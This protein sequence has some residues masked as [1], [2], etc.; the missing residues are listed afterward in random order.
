V[1]QP[2]FCAPLDPTDGGSG[3]SLVRDRLRDWLLGVGLVEPELHE[4]LIAAGEACTNAVEHSGA[5][6]SGGEPA[7][8][9]KGTCDATQVRIVVADRGRWKE[10]ESPPVATGRRGRGRLVMVSLV[11]RMDIRTGPSGTVVELIK[12]RR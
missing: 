11:D 4:V 12:E 9:I 6:A 3:L 5:E 8:W 10:Q 2:N 1:T 7:A